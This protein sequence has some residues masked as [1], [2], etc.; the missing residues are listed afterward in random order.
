MPG[1]RVRRNA[2]LFLR[3]PLAVAEPRRGRA[4]G[5]AAR[6]PRQRGHGV[7]A[8][9]QKVSTQWAELTDE[10]GVELVVI[11]E[12]LGYAH[13]GVTATVYAHVRLRQ[14]SDAIEIL[15]SVVGSR[16]ST[17]TARSEGDEPEP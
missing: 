13:I 1:G 11:K 14:Q 12:L 5:R 8:Q 10:E 17:E 15:S 3:D 6:D 4:G 9:P 7:R 16:E 2:V